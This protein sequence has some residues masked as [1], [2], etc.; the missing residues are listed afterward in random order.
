[1]ATPLGTAFSTDEKVVAQADVQLLS[2]IVESLVV[3]FDQEKFKKFLLRL[4]QPQG[5]ATLLQS[6]F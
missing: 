1:M 3:E 6:F 2:K 4:R 5:N